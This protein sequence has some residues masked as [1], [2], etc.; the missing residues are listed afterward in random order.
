MFSLGIDLGAKGGFALLKDDKILFKVKMP[1]H[2]ETGDIDAYEVDGILAVLKTIVR[3]APCIVQCEA[4]HAIYGSSAKS[5]YSFGSSNG[6]VKGICH[7]WFGLPIEV[8]ALTWQSYLFSKYEIEDIKKKNSTR[9]DTKAMALKLIE[10]LY[11]SEKFIASTRS[12]KPH[13]GIIDAVLIARYGIE[14]CK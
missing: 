6:Y 1:I 9:R 4:L 14:I 8:K 10:K 7:S 2:H 13:D 11:P 5:T 12:S 3:D